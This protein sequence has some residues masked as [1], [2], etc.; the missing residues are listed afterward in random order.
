M[1]Y[2]EFDPTNSEPF[3]NFVSKQEKRNSYIQLAFFGG[4][5]VLVLFLAYKE[6]VNRKDDDFEVS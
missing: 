3:E 5:A 4:L 2:I 1:S 6:Y